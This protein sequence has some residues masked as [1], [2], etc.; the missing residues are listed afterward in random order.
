MSVRDRV[1]RLRRAYAPHEHRP[2]GGY[3]VALGAYAGVTAGLTAVVRATRTPVPDAPSTK[4]IVLLAI[5][6]HKLSRLLTKDAITSPL[7]APFTSYDRP[8]GHG[9][10]MEQVRDQ[11]SSAR[12]ALGEL[13]SCPFC[14]AVWVATGLTG[15]LVLAPRLTRLTAT[16]LTAIAASDF[17]QLAYATAQQA[18]TGPHPPTTPSPPAAASGLGE[19]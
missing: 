19:V 11:G 14:L 15:S 3:L 5:A 1:A 17:L 4:D 7:R 13:L 18:A 9:E 16:A 10:V 12:H 2:L 8:S 6:T